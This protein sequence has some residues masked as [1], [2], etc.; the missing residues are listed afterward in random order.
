MRLARE[1]QLHRPLRIG[2]QPNQPIRIVQQQVGPLVGREAPRESQRQ[3][4]VIEDRRQPPTCGSALGGELTRI[5]LM[6]MR[7]ISVFARFV[8]HLP[9]LRVAQL[10]HVIRDL[11]DRRAS[12]PCRRP[13]STEHRPPPSPTSAHECR[14][15]RS[16][17]APP[18]CGQRGNSGLKD[19]PAHFAVQPA[20]S[21][22]RAAA[23][24]RQV[25]H[26]ERLRGIVRVLP[27]QRQ[28]SPTRS[29]VRLRILARICAS[30]PGRTGRSRPRPPCGS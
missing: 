26:V 28:Q 7:P 22:D 13:S 2:E 21:V 29:P 12:V 20:D 9:E 15:S 1:N 19:P 18:R 6:H 17:P 3:R 5:A 23:A 30:A 8:A 16:R 27:A 11:L 4:V 25:G 14:W 24:H 10:A